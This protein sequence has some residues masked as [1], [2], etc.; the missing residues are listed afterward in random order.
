MMSNQYS[1][2]EKAAYVAGYKRMDGSVSASG[3]AKG[4]GI[5]ASTFNGW[6]KADANMPFGKLQI[7]QSTISYIAKP[8]RNVIVFASENIRI[9]LKENFD[10]EFLNRIMGVLINA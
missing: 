3:F 8:N 1:E 2:E 10:K 5:P 7:E 9:E 4:N 6:L